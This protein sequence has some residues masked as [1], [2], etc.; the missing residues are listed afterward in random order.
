[1]K[2]A[3]LEHSRSVGGVTVCCVCVALSVLL[4]LFLP[5]TPTSSQWQSVLTW[6]TTV[7]WLGRYVSQSLLNQARGTSAG[8]SANGLLLDLV[9]NGANAVSTGLQLSFSTCGC[10]QDYRRWTL[11]FGSFALCSQLVFTS[12]SRPTSPVA[13]S[14]AAL[15]VLL[16]G[17]YLSVLIAL[18]DQPAWQTLNTWA[19][20]LN[21]V[22][23]VCSGFARFIPQIQ[24]YLK[25]RLFLG[26]DVGNACLD[27]LGGVALVVVSA[28]AHTDLWDQVVH[29]AGVVLLSF[30]LLAQRVLFSS[31]PPW[32]HLNALLR[33]IT[34]SRG[35]GRGRG[36]RRASRVTER[37][38]EEVE[39][40]VVVLNGEEGEQ[41]LREVDLDKSWGCP[42]CTLVNRIEDLSCA[43]CGLPTTHPPDPKQSEPEQD[44]EPNTREVVVLVDQEGVGRSGEEE[45]EVGDLIPEATV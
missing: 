34:T 35:G 20:A 23:I 7:C 11:A 24:L 41:Q 36:S 19:T 33:E 27:L 45:E 43:V 5:A 26:Y 4:G 37:R 8:L 14:V 1:M 18:T 32:S 30:C 3:Y 29:G 15:V 44:S 12:D 25:H 17:M 6:C 9:G 13:L 39:D 2:R 10:A 16:S 42:R 21:W 28:Y 22:W 31:L 38:E 40:V